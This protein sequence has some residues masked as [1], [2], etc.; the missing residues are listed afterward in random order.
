MFGGEVFYP[1]LFKLEEC[2]FKTWSLAL[3]ENHLVVCIFNYRCSL[4]CG[5]YIRIAQ[6]S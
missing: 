6:Q 3:Y 4:A 1:T 2:I 5:L